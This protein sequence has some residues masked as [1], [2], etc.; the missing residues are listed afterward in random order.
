[1]ALKSVLRALN[2]YLEE[3][4]QKNTAKE[5]ITRSTNFV[6]QKAVFFR[7]FRERDKNGKI[8]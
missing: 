7:V 5:Y 3:I 4:K 1:M 2:N 8:S 6:G